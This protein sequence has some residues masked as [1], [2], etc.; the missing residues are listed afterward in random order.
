MNNRP[1]PRRIRRAG[2]ADPRPRGRHPRSDPVML[3]IFFNLFMSIAEQ[4]A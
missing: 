4:M 2:G 3:E 1:Q